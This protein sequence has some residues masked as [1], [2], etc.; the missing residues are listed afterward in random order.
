VPGRI[1]QIERRGES[2]SVHIDAG[3]PLLADITPRALREM[4]LK[5]GERVYCLIKT[6]SF[7]YLIEQTRAELESSAP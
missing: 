1:V 7:S 5:E 6:R 4:D 2:V 3:A